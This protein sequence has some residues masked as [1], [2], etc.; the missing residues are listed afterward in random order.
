MNK[1]NSE[2]KACAVCGETLMHHTLLDIIE[3]F[4]KSHIVVSALNER[5]RSLK[6]Q[7]EVYKGA[8]EILDKRAEQIRLL[9]KLTENLIASGKR[10][11][12]AWGTI[13]GGRAEESVMTMEIAILNQIIEDTQW[14]EGQKK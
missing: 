11:Q 12:K 14:K 1:T 8:R 10:I 4:S 9:K 6:E 7:A 13:G 2:L 5:I 3:C